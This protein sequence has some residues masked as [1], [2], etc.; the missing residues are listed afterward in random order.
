MA[1]HFYIDATFT[2]KD[3]Y[4]LLVIM[5]YYQLIDVKVPCAYILMNNKSQISYEIVLNK[6]KDIITYNNNIEL[7]VISISTDF[8]VALINVTKIVFKN[9]RHVGCL[10]HYVKNIRLYLSKLGLYN[11]NT[12]QLSNELLKEL[13][14]IPFK[15]QIDN[16]IF[17]KIF[18][19]FEEK[20]SD[21][22]FIYL[23]IKF[24]QYYKDNWIQHLKSGSLNYIYLS[25]KERS[26][27]Y[28]ENYNR[29]IKEKLDHILAKRGRSIVVWPLF[30]MFI[31]NDENYYNNLITYKLKTDLKNIQNTEKTISYVEKSNELN[32]NPIWLKYNNYSC[33][34][35][36]FF[37]YFIQLYIQN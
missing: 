34:Y 18:R 27:S 13:T 26:N 33:R 8:E 4:Q 21:N 23:Y 14:T 32:N 22:E 3:F 12:T 31:I 10:F 19:I 29:R 37:F 30:I 24:K 17:D 25:K 7:K 16:K 28:I 9:I 15:Y 35:D 11:K 6:L 2:T 5:A 1:E 36:T 20:N